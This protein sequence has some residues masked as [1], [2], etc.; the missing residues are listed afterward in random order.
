[1]DE[2][3]GGITQA[4]RAPCSRTR[5]GLGASVSCLVSEFETHSATG[6]RWV[7]ESPVEGAT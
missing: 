4:C 5:S 7:E 2:Y 6:V 3:S 1:M